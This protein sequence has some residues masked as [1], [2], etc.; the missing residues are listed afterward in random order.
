MGKGWAFDNSKI[1][2]MLNN[3]VFLI[4]AHDNLVYRIHCYPF[5]GEWFSP[6]P[7][8]VIETAV[9]EFSG[10]FDDKVLCDMRWKNLFSLTSICQVAMPNFENRLAISNLKMSVRKIY[11]GRYHIPDLPVFK[12]TKEEERTVLWLAKKAK[13]KIE[14]YNEKYYAAFE[15]WYEQGVKTEKGFV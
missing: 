2:G 1:Y 11:D 5:F 6:S 8:F 9:H 15:K 3:N 13:I 14:W 7:A 12:I 10:M 4:E